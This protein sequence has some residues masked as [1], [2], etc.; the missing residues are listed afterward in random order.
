MAKNIT[1]CKGCGETFVPGVNG[2][3]G[4][5]DECSGAE[6]DQSG[7]VYYPRN[8]KVED[9]NKKQSKSFGQN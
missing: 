2:Q 1:T 4:Y 8:G 6:R 5:C 7:R 3:G 9:L